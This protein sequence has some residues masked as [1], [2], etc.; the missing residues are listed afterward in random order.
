MFVGVQKGLLLCEVLVQVVLPLR[1]VCRCACGEL[2]LH[3]QHGHLSGNA[4][5]GVIVIIIPSGRPQR[6]KCIIH[7]VEECRG[8]TLVTRGGRCDIQMPLERLLD[9]AVELNSS[10]VYFSKQIP[11][12]EHVHIEAC[13][14]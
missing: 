11:I 12:F 8:I 5:R 10:L 7:H 1:H 14:Q 6:S 13:A 3:G 4:V 2:I 9:D